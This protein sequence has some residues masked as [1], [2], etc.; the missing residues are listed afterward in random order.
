M[1]R[2]HSFPQTAG[3]QLFHR[4][5][6]LC[7]RQGILHLHNLSQFVVYHAAVHSPMV[8]RAHGGPLAVAERS[9][10]FA[11]RADAESVAA[12]AVSLDRMVADIFNALRT[13]TR[14]TL[15]P[16]HLSIRSCRIIGLD[17]IA[18]N[19]ISICQRCPTDVG[20]IPPS[21][22]GYLSKLLSGHHILPCGGCG[23]IAVSVTLPVAEVLYSEVVGAAAILM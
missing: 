21:Q 10:V 19:I 23:N 22:S 3:V 4:L 11:Q 18:V 2:S 5:F 6:Y 20:P 15:Y 14:K 16:V 13:R 17:V 8:D 9:D 12:V 1:V 7:R